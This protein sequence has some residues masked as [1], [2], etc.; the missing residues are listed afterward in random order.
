MDTAA[1]SARRNLR[2]SPADDALFRDA[3]AATGESVS[4]FLV[5]S[6]RTRAQTVLTD[7]TEFAL[8]DEDWRAFHAALDRPPIADPAVV[9]L[10]RRPPPR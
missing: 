3:A 10:L 1:K 8:S 4:E 2:V 7:R 9:E 6:G 5:S